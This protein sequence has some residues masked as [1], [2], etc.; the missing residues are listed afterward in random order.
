MSYVGI[1]SA[2]EHGTISNAQY[3][4][5]IGKSVKLLCDLV[6][7]GIFHMKMCPPIFALGLRRHH[8]SSDEQT[9]VS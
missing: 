2:I 3:R 9:L 8:C 1:V 7:T 5:K 6:H 4:M